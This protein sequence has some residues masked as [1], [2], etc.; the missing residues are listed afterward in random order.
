MNVDEEDDND[1]DDELLAVSPQ[2]NFTVQVNHCITEQIEFW[3]RSLSG[4]K[5]SGDLLV[6]IYEEKMVGGR[7]LR[8]WLVKEVIYQL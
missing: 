3:T 1:D 8:L 4:F 6:Y 2:N 7:F 5:P